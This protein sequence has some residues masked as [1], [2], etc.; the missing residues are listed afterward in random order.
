MNNPGHWRLITDDGVSA[1]FGLA[2]DETLCRR[3]GRGESP[4][5]L[6]LYT[7]RSHCVL[8]GRF[9]TAEN[10][11]DLDCCRDHGI[12]VGRRPTGG[13]AILMGED[14]LGIALTLSGQG[15]DAYG[16][17]RE[18]M[19]RF[20]DGLVRGL[21]GFGMGAAFRRKNDV[22]VGGRKVAGLGIYRHAS[23]G[24]LFHA[25][26]LLD[27]DVPLMLCVLKTCFEKISDKG[28]QAMEARICT[29]RGETG[30]NWELDE[31][32]AGMAAAYGEEFGVDLLPVSFTP[33]E[34][35]EIELLERSKYLA[36]DWIFQAGKVQD[37]SG[38]IRV[39][40]PGGLL[41]IRA[42]LAGRTLKAIRL[43]GDFFASESAVADLES[44]LR[45]HPIESGALARTLERVYL[46]RKGELGTI[47]LESLTEAVLSAVGQAKL[48]G[49][50]A[51]SPYGCF[52]NPG[53]SHE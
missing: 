5:T 24:L 29:V 7:Y 46:E 6:R 26:L 2:A 33:E 47:P 31:V 1:S 4:P 12:P 27:L 44:S 30:R 19:A 36:R 25:S 22:E 15:R 40:T 8:V 20:A 42:R 51:A 49:P 48:A 23:G 38:M 28:I 18:L 17:A 53:A 39:K 3:V 16:R 14:Q 37:S 41:E 32:R 13:G 34:R 9:Q 35:R 52:V 11:V 21:K 43:A 10:E 50:E 45:W